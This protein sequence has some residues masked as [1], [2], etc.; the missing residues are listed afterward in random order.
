MVTLKGKKITTTALWID[1]GLTIIKQLS[2]A[3]RLVTEEA[4]ENYPLLW[5]TVFITDRDFMELRAEFRYAS[6]T[7][8]QAFVNSRF[9]FD[10][11]GLPLDPYKAGRI[12]MWARQHLHCGKSINA[13]RALS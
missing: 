1:G 9:T 4:V 6:A 8:Q 12:V 2:N 13:W 10:V 3:C 7:K 5:N 11:K